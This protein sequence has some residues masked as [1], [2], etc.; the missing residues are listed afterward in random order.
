MHETVQEFLNNKRNEEKIKYEKEKQNTLFELGLYEKIPSPY[1]GYN[2]EF[3][4]SDWDDETHTYKYYK[5]APIEVSD[6]EYQEIKKYAIS[7]SEVV[8][9]TSTTPVTMRQINPISPILF[10]IATLEWILGFI[11]G[12][13]VGNVLGRWDFHWGYAFIVW[14]STFI[15]GTT[16]LGFAEIIQLL[17]DIKNK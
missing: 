11:A 5:F 3:P 6:E 8:S 9:N 7:E 12:I 10:F 2:K 14:V 1:N 4:L 17:T 16:F 13:I 15:S